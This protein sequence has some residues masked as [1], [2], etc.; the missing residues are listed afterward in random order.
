MLYKYY[1][2]T[3]R[4]QNYLKMR[5][6]LLI[7][8]AALFASIGCN[9]SQEFVQPLP[10]NT[11]I[12]QPNEIVAAEGEFEINAM[13]SLCYD[14]ELEGVANYLLKYIPL[15][16]KGEQDKNYI[17]LSLDDDLAAEAYEL[18]ID[19]EGISIEGGGYGGVFNGV[20]SLLQMMPAVYLEATKLPLKVCCVE[21]KDAPR[22]EYRGA[23]LDVART[24]MP[25][26]DIKRYIDLMAMHKL[27][28]F[29][30]HL[31]DD[32]GWRIEIKSHPEFAL[33]GGFRGGD[34]KVWPRYSKFDERWGGYYTHEELRDIVAY[35]AER[36]IEVIPEIDF[37]GHSRA[38][39]QICPD[40]LCNYTPDKESWGGRDLRN[41]WCVAKESNYALVEDIIREV[42][43]IFPSE[44]IHIG[45]DEVA[46]ALG[47]HIWSKCPDCTALMRKH[48]YTSYM[49]LQDIFTERVAGILE[50]YG[51]KPAV[52][53]EAIEG[54]RLDKDTKVYGWKNVKVCKESV[55]RGYATV[56][57]PG[58]Y[59]YFDS[60]QSE[61][62]KG[63]KWAGHFDAKK[64]ATFN[65]V[66]QGFTEENMKHVWGISTAFWSELYIDN[67]PESHYYIDYMCFPRFC[68]ASEI[69]WRGQCRWEEFYPSLLSHY[70]RLSNMG[71]SY[72]L[73]SPSVKVENGKIV[74][75]AAEKNQTLYY[76]DKF[77]GKTERYT[78]PLDSHLAS[79]VSFHAEYRTGRSA[80]IALDAY[81]K[82]KRPKMTVTTSLP[83]RKRNSLKDIE[84][85]KIVHTSRTAHAGD[86]LE[87]RFAE[88]VK[89]RRITFATGHP[90]LNRAILEFAYV[91]ASY[92][93]E[94]FEQVGRL[95]L[96]ALA[97]E[98]KSEVHALRVVADGPSDAEPKVV[99]LP[100]QIE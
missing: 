3:K 38:L 2:C 37:P 53:N 18:E 33:E 98:P 30:L 43:E 82:T 72:R 66:D 14:A 27:N 75:T 92:D 36:N 12:P 10:A 42:V 31:T 11:I 21:I 1:I 68:V 7:F 52:W 5:T 79:Q 41:A 54:G 23:H 25:V 83:L 88:P 87:Y 69:A 80:D 63:Q 97:F 22:F 46:L 73:E 96:G 74:A 51:K 64:V 24:Y 47:Y 91:E 50:R 77:T 71:V 89:T 17:K 57:M 55:D 35:A 78:K 56:V 19:S 15:S 4:N 59:F 65:F 9:T 100:L 28:K 94:N 99:I 86:W 34:A 61:H 85:Y 62:E 93:G 32:E 6:K 16:H 84:A 67:N 45:G 90:H 20:Q 60:R 58:G 76:T 48:G 29:H 13:T 81:Y 39:A 26:A 70:E 40:I 49:Q 8:A 95:H 44:Y